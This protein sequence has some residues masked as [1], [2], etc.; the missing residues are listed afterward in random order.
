MTFFLMAAVVVCAIGAWTDFRTGTIPNWLTLGS[1]AAGILGHF[2]R[3][4]AYDGWTEG[5]VQAAHSLAGALVCV[6]VP[7]ILYWRK[8]IG[9]GDVKLFAALGALC[10]P[11]G[12]LEAETYA[13]LAAAL[14]APARLAY[15]G[16]LFQTLGNTLALVVNP[17]RK[18]AAR[19]ELPPEMLTWFRL[20][21]CIFLGTF[22]MLVAH[23]DVVQLGL[24][25]AP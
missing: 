2:V 8:A 14:I 20:G 4:Y 15:K 23:W 13:F 5:A 1:L 18:K 11:L 10:H 9:G 7:G 3:G 21:P 19:K 6:L 22:S 24:G 16:V 12:G 25:R 17:F